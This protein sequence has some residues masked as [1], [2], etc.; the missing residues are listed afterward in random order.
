[1]TKLIVLKDPK[2]I[3]NFIIQSIP[4]IKVEVDDI[5]RKLINKLKE[6]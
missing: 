3:K 5:P 2:K 4:K 1:V 6:D